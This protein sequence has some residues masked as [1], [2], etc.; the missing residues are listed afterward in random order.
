MELNRN[1][2]HVKFYFW[3]LDVW[4]AFLE[5]YTDRHQ[6]NLCQYIRT[7]FVWMPLAFAM[8]VGLLLYALYV[9]FYYPLT[10]F[11]VIGSFKGYVT[12]TLIV[13]TIYLFFY[14]KKKRAERLREQ[15]WAHERAT[16]VNS[17]DDEAEEKEKRGPGFIEVI[18]LYLVAMKQKVC[19]MIEFKA[20]RKQEGV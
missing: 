15:R 20:G 13:G 3:C 17:N 11:G 4:D 6:S 12:V 16:D 18:W 2:W 9:L 5:T 19:P 10:R 14:M 8:N 1:Q 7:I